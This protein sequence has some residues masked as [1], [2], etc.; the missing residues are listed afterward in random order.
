MKTLS[1]T[2]ALVLI[3]NFSA[4]WAAEPAYLNNPETAEFIDSFIETLDQVLIDTNRELSAKN[5][6][7]YCENL[8]DS[9]K[10]LIALS[11][12]FG[13]DKVRGTVYYKG[14]NE[15]ASEEWRREIAED[16]NCY[17]LACNKQKR[18]SLVGA[19]C[20]SRAYGKDLSILQKALDKMAGHEVSPREALDF[21]TH[22]SIFRR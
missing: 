6:S 4:S 20:N 15:V 1:V 5:K 16:L 22:I 10:E 17:A 13:W 9:Q 8:S 7:L 14:L 21:K 3:F 12:T 2:A 19:I 11:L 18:N